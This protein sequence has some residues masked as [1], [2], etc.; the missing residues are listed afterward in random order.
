MITKA[1]RRYASALLQLAKERDNVESV[2]N[3]IE[4]IK[5]TI[6]DSREL[7][8]FLRSPIIN[9]DD[10]GKALEELFG[11]RVGELIQKFIALMA[12]KDRV[13]ILYQVTQAFIELY[14][15]Y[16][17][18]I[19]IQVTSA[20]PLSDEQEQALHDALEQKTGKKVNLSL[21]VDESLKG[22]LAVRIDDTVID[23]TIKHKLEQL[24]ESF[25]S[26]A[27]E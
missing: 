2:L 7:E 4:L 26:T 17:G 16:A 11:D 18:I 24:E 21:S 5:N 22:G 19:E 27:A 25:L 15:E 8:L 13:A 20:A 23:G 1:A 9:F 3:D 12:R 6:D 10:K 14:N